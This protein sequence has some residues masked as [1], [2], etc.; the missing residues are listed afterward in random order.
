MPSF[1]GMCSG[2]SK[3]TGVSVA[4]SFSFGQSSLSC[5]RNSGP[6]NFHRLDEVMSMCSM[7]LMASSTFFKCATR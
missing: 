1:I 4:D 5:A 6:L 2:K 3:K 7:S